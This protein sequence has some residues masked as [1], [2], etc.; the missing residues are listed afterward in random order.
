MSK[1]KAA[2]RANQEAVRS[3]AVIVE[4][5]RLAWKEA[6]VLL[7]RKGA[8]INASSRGY[9]ALHSLIQERPLA[10]ERSSNESRVACLKWML[11]NGA[12]TERLAAFPSMRA[13]QTAAFA[14]LPDYGWTAVHQAASRGNERMLR[15]V[16]EAGG[17][18]RRPDKRGATPI[19]IARERGRTKLAELFRGR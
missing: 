8:D 4:A 1:L 2:V 13:I 15:A 3:P 11:A 10:E 12:D 5:G 14:G 18:E 7:V 9:R 16:L 19:E 17:D 6:L